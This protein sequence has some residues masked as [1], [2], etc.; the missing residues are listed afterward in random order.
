M[1]KSELV[2]HATNITVLLS[3][4][5]KKKSD[6]RTRGKVKVIFISH[7]SVAN[8]F[9]FRLVSVSKV[10]QKSKVFLSIC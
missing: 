9:S 8:F 3:I 5:P 4:L 10:K 7:G 2:I 6:N 1:R